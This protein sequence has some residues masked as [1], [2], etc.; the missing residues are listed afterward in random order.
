MLV[1][2]SQPEETPSLKIHA[3]LK[4][5]SLHVPTGWFKASHRILFH[6]F[7]FFLGGGGG[8]CFCC[9]FNTSIWKDNTNSLFTFGSVQSVI[10]V[11]SA[12]LFFSQFLT[13]VVLLHQYTTMCWFLSTALQLIQ[14]HY[15]L[16]VLIHHM[17]LLCYLCWLLLWLFV[18][19][20]VLLTTTLLIHQYATYVLI[21][22]YGSLVNSLVPLTTKVLIYQ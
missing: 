12:A 17:L 19:S 11:D 13:A 3:K 15:S 9:L 6:P 4:T 21:H 10:C 14:Q 5:T 16:P 22:Q 20:S 18:N 2:I 7:F 1:A 8:G